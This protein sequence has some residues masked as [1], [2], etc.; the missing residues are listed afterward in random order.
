VAKLGGRR[1]STEPSL[2]GEAEFLRKG[3]EVSGKQQKPPED[4]IGVSADNGPVVEEVP[5]FI[6]F[7]CVINVR[8]FG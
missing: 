8:L 6:P 2:R 3:L 4:I 7:V 1:G 5:P